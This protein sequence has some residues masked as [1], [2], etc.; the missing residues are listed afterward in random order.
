MSPLPLTHPRRPLAA[1]PLRGGWGG[2]IALLVFCLALSAA[3]SMV[4]AEDGSADLD[5]ATELQITARSLRDLEEVAR[6]CESALKAGLSEADQG[7][8]KQLLSSAMLQYG[9]RVAAGALAEPRNPRWQLLR[10]A[11]MQSLE[12]ALEYSPELGE[13]HLLV[14]KLQ[15]LPLGDEKRAMKAADGAVAAFEQDKRK[16]AEAL[17]MRAKM[18]E[19]AEKR[20]ADIQRVID[21]DGGN[22]EAWRTLAGHYFAEGKSD[23]ALQAFRKVVEID[24]E[25]VTAKL[26]LAEALSSMDREDEAKELVDRIIK[27]QPDAAEAYLMRGQLLSSQ[28]KYKEAI[29]AISQAIKLDPKNFRSYLFRAELRLVS[30]DLK[31]AREDCDKLLEQS[32]GLVAG[33]LTRARIRAADNDVAGAIEDIELVITNSRNPPSDWKL[34]LAAYYSLDK[35]P[36]RAIK[37]I[38]EVVTQEAENWRALRTRGDTYLAIGSHKEAIADY[39]AALKIKGDDSGLLNN[40]A[41]VLAT[42][43]TDELRNAKRSIELAT[44]ACDLTEYKEAHILSTLASGYAESG[45]FENAKKWST[46]AVE[47]GEGEMK[48]QLKQELENYEKGKPWRE[49]QEQKEKVTTPP[50]GLLET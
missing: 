49:L 39:E 35:Q 44:K 42:S 27:E 38:S 19:D 43:P 29:D 28:E 17:L 22:V 41:W 37:I 1:R 14:A 23:E 32:P 3:P 46:K 47:L 33:Y 25:N 26:A 48:E 31:G 5:K 10:Q 12:R 15:T 34:Q 6:L 18:Q 40:L 20:L 7:F 2:L 11:A 36:R 30:D 8:A 24:P 16:L 45:D 4:R 9:E 50:S 21:L 13:A